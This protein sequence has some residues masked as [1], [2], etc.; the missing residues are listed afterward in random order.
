MVLRLCLKLGLI[1]QLFYFEEALDL[2]NC[3]SSIDYLQRFDIQADS[4]VGQVLLLQV[5]LMVLLVTQSEVDLRHRS[6][7]AVWTRV[8][9]FLLLFLTIKEFIVTVDGS[10]FALLKQFLE[11]RRAINMSLFVLVDN[12]KSIALESHV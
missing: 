1:G 10:V 4:Q 3:V 2:T 11:E 7:C 12:E 8:T 9:I 6:G 5:A